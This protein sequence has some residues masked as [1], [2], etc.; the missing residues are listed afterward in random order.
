MKHAR[1]LLGAFVA[2]PPALAGCGAVDA[3]TGTTPSGPA[4]GQTLKTV[5]VATRDTPGEMYEARNRKNLCRCPSSSAS[6]LKRRRGRVTGERCLTGEEA[7]GG[8][9]TG[10]CR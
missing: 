4:L 5:A 7:T 3:Q 9:R 6:P 1:I 8:I 10:F 2:G